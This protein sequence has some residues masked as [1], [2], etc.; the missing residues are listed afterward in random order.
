M[1]QKRVKIEALVVLRAEDGKP[2]QVGATT[3][4]LESTATI[5]VN[6]KKAK[7][8]KTEGAKDAN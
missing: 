4:V 5:L 7:L 8:V 6:K 2:V 1:T 3:E